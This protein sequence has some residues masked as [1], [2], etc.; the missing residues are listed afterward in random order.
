MPLPRPSEG[1]TRGVRAPS[2]QVIFGPCHT[3]TYIKH[4]IGA[5]LE[6]FRSNSPQRARRT[7]VRYWIRAPLSVVTTLNDADHATPSVTGMPIRK[8]FGMIR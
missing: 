2:L 8:V 5:P 7:A 6:I 1:K 4:A 3:T